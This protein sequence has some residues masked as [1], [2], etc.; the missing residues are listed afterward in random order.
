MARPGRTIDAHVMVGTDDWLID[1][2]PEVTALNVN[3]STNVT[4]QPGLG[5]RYEAATFNT[6][7]H[8]IDIPTLYVG[9][10]SDALYGYQDDDVEP[11]VVVFDPEVDLVYA[12][13]AVLTGLPENAPT[14]DVIATSINF[15]Q[16]DR[17]FADGAGVVVDWDFTATDVS[18]PV[19]AISAGKDVFLVVTA[20]A[21][22]VSAT[23]T[24]GDGTTDLTQ[25]A[26]DGPGVYHVGAVGTTAIGSTGVITVPSSTFSGTEAASGYVLVAEEVGV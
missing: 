25:D 17:F 18:E 1:L 12:M 10:E 16:A 23:V 14:S 2:T 13:D 8:S 7:T 24:I 20:W 3:G 5:R 21:S 6:G 15:P 9:T 19:G 26:V 11:W 4:R 22:D